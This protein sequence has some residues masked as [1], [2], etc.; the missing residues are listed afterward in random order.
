MAFSTRTVLGS[1]LHNPCWANCLTWYELACP[2]RTIRPGRISID[3]S[4]TRRPVLSR[5]TRSK[6]SPCGN[7]ADTMLKHPRCDA[8]HGRRP[9]R[10][11]DYADESPV[12]TVKYIKLEQF[13]GQ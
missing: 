13:S 4:R 6:S 9:P 7:A 3:R 5:T 10:S 12:K 1:A 2:C 11:M 8:G